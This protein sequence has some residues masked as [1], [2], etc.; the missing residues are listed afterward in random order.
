MQDMRSKAGENNVPSP[1]VSSNDYTKR[2]TL[3]INLLLAPGAG[4]AASLLTV[5]LMGILRLVAG[6]PTPVELFGDFVLK[7][8]DVGTFLRL[9]I[10]FAPN[11]KTVPL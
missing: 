8:I 10:T 1:T 6:I 11:S 7:H 3:F 9:L 5:V 2:R 4:L